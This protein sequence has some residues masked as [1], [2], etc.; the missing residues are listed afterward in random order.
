MGKNYPVMQLE[1][2]SP[3]PYQL[4]AGGFIYIGVHNI[5][6]QIVWLGDV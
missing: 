6:T 1:S 4:G 5:G 2:L 3:E